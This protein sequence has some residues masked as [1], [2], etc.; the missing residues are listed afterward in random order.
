MRTRSDKRNFVHDQRGSSAVEFA[1]VVPVLLTVL[2]GISEY[3][4]YLGAA[5]NVTELAAD[6]ARASVAGITDA[7]RSA[8]AL[9]TIRLTA[10]SY[11][12][13]GTG[14][15]TAEAGVVPEDPTEF[16]VVASFD[17]AVMSSWGLAGILPSL[18]HMIVRA[19]TIKR[20][21]Y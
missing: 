2:F 10:G 21:G 14:K 19:A 8:I 20:G 3:G 18:P 15:L 9:Q 7:E 5:N 1:M 16:R 6:A 4:V 17:A 12:L 13:L 11:P